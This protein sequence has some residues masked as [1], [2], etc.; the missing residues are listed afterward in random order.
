MSSMDSNKRLSVNSGGQGGFAALRHFVRP[1]APFE[2]CELC[3]A[4][5]SGEHQHLLNP[6]DR[7]IVCACDPCAILFSGQAGA[8]YRR[9]PRNARLLQEFLMRDEEWESLMI[10]INLA[11]F[12]HSSQAG[13]MMAI[14]P[15]PAGATESLLHLESWGEIARQNPGL[16]QMK[17]DVEALLINRVGD[18]REYYL[19][20]I[21]RCYRLVGLIRT[22]WHGLSGGAEVW[23]Q[24]DSFF[25]ELKPVS[26]RHRSTTC[27]T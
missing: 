3:S 4:E 15:S 19:A 20:P 13:R 21:D 16:E 17:P 23:K 27:L 8:K 22:H 12:F 1:P 6:S 11:F 26:Y 2:R 25:S 18:H 24:I 7:N 5:L 9:I 14:Y 10:P